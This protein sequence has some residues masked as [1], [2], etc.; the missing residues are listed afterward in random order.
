VANE[1][2]DSS[3]KFLLTDDKKSVEVVLPSSSENLQVASIESAFK[4]SEFNEC[5]FREDLVK[6]GITAFESSKGAIPEDTYT[7]KVADRKS[8]TL[9]LEVTPDRLQANL[10]ITAAFGGN[11][12]SEKLILTYLKKQ[13]IKSGIKLK[14]IQE[15]CSNTGAFTPG[16]QTSI[17]VAKG[18]P[19]KSGIPC[20][21]K[22]TVTPFQDRNLKPVE[23]EDGTTD[24]Y[25]LGEI[26]TVS[27]GDVVMVRIPARKNDDGVNVYGE[28]IMSIA[29]PNIAFETAEGVEVSDENPNQLIATRS[30]VPM[31][32]RSVIRVDDILVLDSVDLTT[33]HIE[34]DGTVMIKGPVRDGLKVNVSGDIH[35]RDLVESATLKAGGNIVIKQGILGRKVETEGSVNLED[36]YSSIVEA[37]GDIEA[38]YIQYASVNV[39]GKIVVKDQLL[40]SFVKDCD[41]LI[42]G[43]PTKRKAKLVGGYYNIRKSVSVGILGSESYVASDIVLGTDVARLKNEV[44]EI[45]NTLLEKQD[46]LVRCTAQLEKFQQKGDQAKVDH[47]TKTITRI[48]GEARDLKQQ[49]ETLSLEYK[50]LLSHISVTVY[51]ESYPGTQLKFGK[52]ST[53]LQE[54]SAACRFKFTKMGLKKLSLKKGG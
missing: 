4:S 51:G 5:L 26:E 47:F 16:A 48:R 3:F 30:G 2:V 19:A 25:D 39:G 22:W 40:N 8:A 34:F 14:N 13:G 20:E 35:V 46:S 50:D 45:K 23:R 37:G 42:V 54:H 1:V 9:H 36:A 12:P 17:V 28:P 31:R 41:E 38:R 44:E 7:F 18:A 24:M 15:Y 32:A 21:F 43:G 49:Y 6:Q 53:T 52:F 27:P 29:P 10:V 33:G 11:N